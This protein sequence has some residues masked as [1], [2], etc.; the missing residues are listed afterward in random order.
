MWCVP[1]LL[2]W[3]ALGSQMTTSASLADAISPFFGVHAEESRGGS[4]RQLHKTVERQLS[5]VD[6]S[7]SSRPAWWLRAKR[8]AGRSWLP[9]SARSERGSTSI[10][11]AAEKS[12][13][14]PIMDPPVGGAQP[15]EIARPAPTR[16]LVV[17]A[18]PI[19][20]DSIGSVRQDIL[21]ATVDC[22]PEITR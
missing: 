18:K 9:G 21:R 16:R 13:D 17:P 19:P 6:P 12:S 11:P 4:G 2:L 22:H 7:S 1:A 8:P 3:A 10:L 5:G 14:G 20:L 15:R